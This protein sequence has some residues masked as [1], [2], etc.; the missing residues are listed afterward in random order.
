MQMTYG[1][2][3]GD[4]TALRELAA[5][6]DVVLLE[7]AAH[8]IGGRLDG[9]SLGRF[10]V[11]GGYSFF[12]NKNLAVGEGGAVVTDDDDLA[13]RMRLLRSHGMTSLRWD[14]HR[15]HAAGYDVVALGFNYR[16]DEPRAALA[17]RRLVRLDAETEDRARVAA[18][19]ESAWAT[20]PGSRPRC[21]AHGDRPAHHLYTVVL[22]EM[23]DR[24]AF[25][26]R[27]AERGIQTSMHYPP[28]HRFSIYPRR[29]TDRCPSRTSTLACGD[30]AAVR[31]HDRGRPGPRDRRR[32]RRSA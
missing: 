15:G 26:E 3:A 5:A 2:F 9:T 29:R 28:A 13:A 32:G 30:A 8:G 6:R 16:I 22:D 4:A 21:G 14:R 17:R 7:D 27:L 20:S 11:A 10:G 24:D 23:I 1:G 19:Y 18:R 12:S 25:R 31:A